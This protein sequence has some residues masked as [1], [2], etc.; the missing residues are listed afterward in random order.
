MDTRHH[1]FGHQ[2]VNMILI[3]YIAGYIA[4]RLVSN[5]SSAE[6]VGLL[7]YPLSL[8]VV[9]VHMNLLGWWLSRIEVVCILLQLRCS[10]L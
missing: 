5:L 9:R 3:N 4:M 7:V 6:C 1:I 2:V 8:A 10:N